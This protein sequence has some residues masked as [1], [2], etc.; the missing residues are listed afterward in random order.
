M[1]V[2]RFVSRCFCGFSLVGTGAES[3]YCMIVMLVF[4]IWLYIACCLACLYDCLLVCCLNV[5]GLSIVC[6]CIGIRL[7]VVGSF[8]AIFLIVLFRF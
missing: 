3:M 7:L 6:L 2:L 4:W 1:M 5:S 8:V